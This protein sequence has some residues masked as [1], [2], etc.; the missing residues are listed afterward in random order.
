MPA[1]TLSGSLG[2]LAL[3]ATMD[4]SLQLFGRSPDL[5]PEDFPGEHDMADIC[6]PP[7]CTTQH[8]AQFGNYACDWVRVRVGNKWRVVVANWKIRS[9]ATLPWPRRDEETVSYLGGSERK[10][11]MDAAESMAP[12]LCWVET[13]LQDQ[14]RV[15]RVLERRTHPAGFF[16]ADWDAAADLCASEGIPVCEAEFGSLDDL[17]GGDS[18][19]QVLFPSKPICGSDIVLRPGA[20]A[21][22]C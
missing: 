18:R 22:S 14:W 15:V 6:R 9:V 19:H 21:A 7:P 3:T 1:L 13:W 2:S 17:A 12:G 11:Y 5:Q 8:L 20:K 16:T 10:R 4:A